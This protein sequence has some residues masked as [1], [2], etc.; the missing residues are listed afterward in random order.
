[1]SLETDG[2]VPENNEF[3]MNPKQLEYFKSKLI[4]WRDQI[5]KDYSETITDLQD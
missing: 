4:G 5:L 2:Y 1:M 3:F